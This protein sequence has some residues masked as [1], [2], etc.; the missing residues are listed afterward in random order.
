MTVIFLTTIPLDVFSDVFF[1]FLDVILLCGL[2]QVEPFF[3][4]THTFTQTCIYLYPYFSYDVIWC[5]KYVDYDDG[6]VTCFDI[7]CFI[8]ICVTQFSIIAKESIQMTFLRCIF[9]LRIY[10]YQPA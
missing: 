1:A 3:L 6:L 4:F 10:I 5:F 7:M 2:I 8:L 9:C